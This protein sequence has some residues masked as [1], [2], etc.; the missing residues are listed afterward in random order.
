MNFDENFVFCR[1]ARRRNGTD[2]TDSQVRAGI[3][4]LDIPAS[5]D[6]MSSLFSVIGKEP[7]ESVEMA[8]I[9]D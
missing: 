8:D 1:F 3:V 6:N 9:G 7:T 2:Y 4:V 5:W